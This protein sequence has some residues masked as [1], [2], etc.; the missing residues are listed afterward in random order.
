MK[1]DLIKALAAEKAEFVKN[2]TAESVSVNF[3]GDIEKGFV[4][5]KSSVPVKAVVDGKVS[6]V[7]HFNISLISALAAL[8]ELL[9]S[10]VYHHCKANPFSLEDM[11]DHASMDVIQIFKKKDSVYNN[12]FASNPTPLTVE[13]DKYFNNIDPVSL[14]DGAKSLIK[15]IKLFRNFGASIIA[16]SH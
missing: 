14:S 9:G 15:Q 12:P 2:V 6:E 4:N 10:S 13:E 5:I 3:S 11:L 8:K 7:N 16:G 1:E